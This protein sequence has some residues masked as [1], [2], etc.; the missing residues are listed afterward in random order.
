MRRQIEGKFSIE[1]AWDERSESYADKVPDGAWA[2]FRERLQRAYAALNEAWEEDPSR[3][4]SATNMLALAMGFG[5]SRGQMERWFQRAMEAD[6]GNFEAC[7]RK[8][9]LLQPKWEGSFAEMLAFGRQ[10]AGTKN[11]DARLPLILFHAH[12]VDVIH[13]KRIDFKPPTI[14]AE[15]REMLEPHLVRHPTDR[16]ALTLYGSLAFRAGKFD[17]AHY[18]LSKLD[19]KPVLDPLTYNSVE[20]FVAD[21]WRARTVYA[22]RMKPK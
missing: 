18:L 6:P 13:F 10:C 19:K 21:A 7:T 8:L 15:T 5:F 17:L 11:W 22:D 4:E 16:F 20:Q 9:F 2:L 1:Y 12:A 3:P 14:W